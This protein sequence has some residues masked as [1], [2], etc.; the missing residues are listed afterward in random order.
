MIRV[1]SAASD[2]MVE[3]SHFRISAW[4][5]CACSVEATL[6]VPMALLQERHEK[7]FELADEH[8]GC[9]RREMLP[10]WLISNDYLRPVLC[11]FRDGLQ[12][13]CDNFE[14]LV[15]FS[16]LH[17]NQHANTPIPG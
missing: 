5:S 11:D 15:C 16:L 8:D 2:E 10:D 7:Q 12:L 9:W 17:T 14:C 6:P 13:A 1:F 4:T 3:A